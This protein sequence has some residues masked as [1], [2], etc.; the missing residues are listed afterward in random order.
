MSVILGVNAYHAD[1]AVCLVINGVLHSAVAEERLGKRDKHSPRFPE[2]A[3]KRVLNDAGLRLRDVTHIAVPRDP[4]A[5]YI[6]KFGYVASISLEENRPSQPS[7]DWRK[8]AAR[9]QRE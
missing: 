8:C 3:I 4:K 1:S 5:N 2:N 6:A 9:I 7:I